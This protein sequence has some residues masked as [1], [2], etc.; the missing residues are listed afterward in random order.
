LAHPPDRTP[1]TAASL[2][3]TLP[4]LSGLVVFDSNRGG[5]FGIYAL[6]PAT[7]AIT[8]LVDTAA[9]EMHPQVSP[10]GRALAYSSAH[11]PHR[12]AALDTWI[13]EGDSPPRLLIK[14]AAYPSFSPD[15]QYIYFQRNR[16]QIVRF[17]RKSL[18]EEILFPRQ[19]GS[20]KGKVVT[21]PRVSPDGAWV[22][23]TS[24]FPK[25]W[26]TW[27][28]NLVTLEEVRIGDGCQP[29]WSQDS[30]SIYF[31]KESDAKAGSGIFRFDLGAR[32]TFKVLDED[33]RFGK[34]YFPSIADNQRI[35]W[36]ASS[37]E[38]H[39]HIDGG[40]QLFM[41]QEGQIVQLTNDT[42]TNRWPIIVP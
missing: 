7:S 24:D 3:Q 33:G 8:P 1:T 39:S 35:L 25:Q 4:S 36:A 28:V 9:H 16:R 11:S 18:R 17:D 31:V 20:F 37:K 13:I 14:D 15:G 30:R 12:L 38:R 34:E 40:Y 10:D 19:E 23:F 41:Q 42:A 21:I 5:N 26:V 2:S 29:Y 32:H 27:A 6:N 22:A